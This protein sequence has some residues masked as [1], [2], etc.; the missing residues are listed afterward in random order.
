MDAEK[1]S[2]LHHWRE[3][4]EEHEKDKK[5]KPR[6]EGDHPMEERKQ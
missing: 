3:F 1:E 2:W 4:R 6:S 5:P